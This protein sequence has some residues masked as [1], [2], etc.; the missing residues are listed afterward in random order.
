[1]S[2]PGDRRRSEGAS[3]AQGLAAAGPGVHSGDGRRPQGAGRPE[4]LA[5]AGPE[6]HSGDGRGGQGAG[7]A[8]ELAIP[9][10]PTYQGDQGGVEGT[11]KGPAELP[12]RAFAGAERG[13]PTLSLRKITGVP[14]GPGPV[15]R[16]PVVRLRKARAPWRKSCSSITPGWSPS[17]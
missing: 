16:V 6:R 13:S 14:A 2:D 12:D 5:V 4:G 8:E 1:Q 15:R 11:A 9:E 17:G 7:G 10:P 3:R